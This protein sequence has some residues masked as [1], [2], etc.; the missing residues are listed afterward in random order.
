MVEVLHGISE[1]TYRIVFLCETQRRQIRSERPRSRTTID[2]V[3]KYKKCHQNFND[4]W[5]KNLNNLSTNQ[6][7]LHV[8]KDSDTEAKFL[9]ANKVSDTGELSALS[10]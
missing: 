7:F 2:P 6:Q 1:L 8:N 3:L 9:R 5:A 10:R 4:L